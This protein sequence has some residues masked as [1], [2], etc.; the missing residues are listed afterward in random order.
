MGDVVSRAE[1]P[2][3]LPTQR[4]VSLDVY[5]IGNSIGVVE[6]CGKPPRGTG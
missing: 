2:A 5:G 1:E 6:V 3:Q 4:P